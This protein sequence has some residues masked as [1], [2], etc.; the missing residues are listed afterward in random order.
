MPKTPDYFKG[1]TIVITG[2]GSGIGQSTAVIFGRE[3]ANV[4]CADIDQKNA[5]AVARETEDA[6]GLAAGIYVDV[7]QRESVRAMISKSIDTYGQ[8]DFLFNHQKGQVP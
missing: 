8:V 2:A 6:G 4:I 5:M 7:T 1:K 3:G